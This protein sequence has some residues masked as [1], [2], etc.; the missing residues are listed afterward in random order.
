MTLV[1]KQNIFHSLL[2]KTLIQKGR[3]YNEDILHSWLVFVVTGCQLFVIL[4]NVALWCASLRKCE[5]AADVI[6]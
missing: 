3:M 5:L 6:Q 4:N 1:I 2:A